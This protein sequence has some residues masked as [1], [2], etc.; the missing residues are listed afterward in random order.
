VN[1]EPIEKK[2]LIKRLLF[3]LRWFDFS[4]EEDDLEDE[5]PESLLLEEVLPLEAELPDLPDDELP[6]ELPD[7]LEFEPDENDSFLLPW[8]PIL[9]FF[10]T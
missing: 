8:L 9:L 4:F 7:D 2:S 1:I 10:L 5:V 3:Y 6:E